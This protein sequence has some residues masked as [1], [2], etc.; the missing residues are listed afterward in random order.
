MPA[1]TADAHTRDRSI[2]FAMSRPIPSVAA[3]FAK[4]AKSLLHEKTCCAAT[5]QT[6]PTI[7]P[8]NAVGNRHHQDQGGCPRL[9][10]LAQQ[11]ESSAKR[12]SPASAASPGT[13]NVCHPSL[14]MAMAIRN[15]SRTS[16]LKP[17]PGPCPQDLASPLHC[18]ICLQDRSPILPGLSLQRQRIQP[19][20][21]R[22]RRCSPT[23]CIY[24]HRTARQSKTIYTAIRCYT[25][26]CI[27]LLS[28]WTKWTLLI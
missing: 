20:D 6:M 26:M 3:L 5:S 8:R 16:R 4:S 25:I 11:P 17:L 27:P 21:P 23:M 13:W 24:Q 9:A 2:L 15:P 12:P 22:R 1:A 10:A 18:R 19:P 14:A 28:K 7:H